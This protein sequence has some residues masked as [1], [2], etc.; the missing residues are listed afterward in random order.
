MFRRKQ[1]KI[2]P[3]FSS[4]EKSEHKKVTNLLVINLLLIKLLLIK[5]FVI[6]LLL[7]KKRISCRIYANL[8]LVFD[9]K[10]NNH[11]LCS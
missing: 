9:K 8:T 4:K 5:L 3:H 10:K 6:N 11:Y 7:A 2:Q 1:R